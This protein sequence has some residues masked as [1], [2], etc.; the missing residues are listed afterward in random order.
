[1][2][3]KYVPYEPA[4]GAEM[5]FGDQTLWIEGRLNILA[6]DPE[7]FIFTVMRDEVP[8]AAMGAIKC[9]K[10]VF[11]LSAAICDDSRCFYA[12][13]HRSALELMDRVK[14]SQNV[15]R[16]QMTVDRQ[17]KSGRRWADALGFTKEAVLKNYGENKQDHVL[18]RRLY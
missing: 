10:G 6:S 2:K 17:F 4:H 18:Y 13:I 5:I 11:E 1:M 14:T 15:H 9:R 7:N 8:L 3:V 12:T 16:F